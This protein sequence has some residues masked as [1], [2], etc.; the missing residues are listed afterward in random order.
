VPTEN[1]PSSE[2][3]NLNQ[4]VCPSGALLCVPDEMLPG[5]PGPQ[6][7]S[8]L[9]GAEGRCY[10]DCLNLGLGQVFPQRDCPDNHTCVPC[11]AKACN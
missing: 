3:A 4:D 10:S 2:V 6:V 7:C 8:G 9:L 1:I 11:W 5:G